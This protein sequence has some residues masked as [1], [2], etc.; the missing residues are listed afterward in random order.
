MLMLI[1]RHFATSFIYTL[2]LIDE[3]ILYDFRRNANWKRRIAN[4]DLNQI[5]VAH[6]QHGFIYMLYVVGNL[7]AAD[8]RQPDKLRLKFQFRPLFVRHRF[9][10]NKSHG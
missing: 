8:V 5:L 1:V 7:N 4:L 10:V 2:K 3:Y 6:D 9:E